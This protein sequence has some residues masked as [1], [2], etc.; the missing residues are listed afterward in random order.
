MKKINLE[1]DIPKLRGIITAVL[2]VMAIIMI[3]FHWTEAYFVYVI[4]LGIVAILD[5]VR[6]KM[7]RHRVYAIMEVCLAVFCF[8]MAVYSFFKYNM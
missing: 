8:V 3:V 1:Y 4:L 6:E 2:V 5:A 7:E